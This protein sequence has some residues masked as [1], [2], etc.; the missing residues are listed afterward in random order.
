LG[1]FL[2]LFGLV[3]SA[4]RWQRLLAAQAVYVKFIPLYDSYI[5]CSFFSLFMPTRVGGD[6]VR[7]ADLRGANQSIMRSASSV[8]IERMLGISVLF[9]FAL[10][11]SLASLALPQKMPAIWIGISLGVCGFLTLLF[12]FYTPV[13]GWFL[14]LLPMPNLR[15]RIG[16]AWLNF[17]ESSMHILSQRDA[18]LWGL[19]Y[20]FLLQLLVVVQFW[21]I[22]K[23]IGISVP[24]LDYFV[25]IPIQ[26]VLLMLPTI[27][28]IGL[29]EGSCIVL[30]GFYGVAAADAVTFGLID[31]AN[32]VAL[33][34]IGWLR[35]V[36]RPS[37]SR[38]FEQI[39]SNKS[40]LR[41][42]KK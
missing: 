1:F 30:F 7:I 8:V 24:M 33:G 42:L 27:N 21:L 16:E 5:V 19:W 29:R 17:R 32:M 18:L 9:F 13:I 34:I 36:N 3:F 4:L 14:S 31:L 12:A 23:A 6:V 40:E 25:L 38:R 10:C 22:G 28:G 35:F 15:L 11:A 20:S 26:A 39:T 41:L 37:H 2:R